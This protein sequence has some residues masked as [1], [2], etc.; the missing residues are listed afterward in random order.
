MVIRVVGYSS[1]QGESM[2]ER[3]RKATRWLSVGLFFFG[4]SV[5]FLGF[6]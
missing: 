5:G 2:S 3:I 4:F 1:R 6:V